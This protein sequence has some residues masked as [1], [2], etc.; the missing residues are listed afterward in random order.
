MFSRR[1]ALAGGLA[2]AACSARG[3]AD[4]AQ[5]AEFRRLELD[6]G[7]GGRL[8]VAA[9][10]TATGARIGF[11]AG[12]RFAMASTFK[13]LLAAAALE[14]LDHEASIAIEREDLVTYSPVTGE[15][16]GGAMSVAQ[17][18]E[19]A[20]VI[21]DNSAANLLL[22][23][24]EGPA[25]FTAWLRQK[26]DAVTR[27][28]RW[29][30]DLNE[31]A[32]GDARDT[33]TPLAQVDGLNR[34]LVGDALRRENR[35]TLRAWMIAS[36][37]GLQRIRGGLPPGWRVGDKTGTGMNGA[38]ND[39]AIA[40]PP[41]GDA[42]LIAVYQDAGNADAETRNRIHREVGALVADWV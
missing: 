36:R 16:V 3:D 41:Q 35:E 14:R 17:L 22:R 42:I 4:E 5:L 10:N 33:T 20:V 1:A 18:A 13:W 25:G 26:G 29:E 15:H 30:T 9:L 23:E 34:L 37:T 24:L 7:P 19:A 6:L 28:D 39:V 12:E 38:V 40:W 31:N 21:S 27:L 11:R 2:L 8:G 32:P